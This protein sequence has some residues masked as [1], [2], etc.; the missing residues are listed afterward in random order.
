RAAAIDREA[1][2]AAQ[3]RDVER[4]YW[5]W[6]ASVRAVDIRR[7]SLELAQGQERR[8]RELIREGR[9]APSDALLAEQIVADRR[10]ALAVA[11][12][13]VTQHYERLHYL[14]GDA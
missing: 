5:A 14:M 3:L 8:T 6:A 11:Q 13:T 1:E 12:S 2:L 10:D 4:E 7:A 9:Q